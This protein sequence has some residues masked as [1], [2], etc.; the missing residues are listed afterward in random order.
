MLDFC[1]GKFVL[2][3]IGVMDIV[4]LRQTNY[5]VSKFGRK[6]PNGPRKLESCVN[7]G[8]PWLDY[9]DVW[10]TAENFDNIFFVKPRSTPLKVTP[11]STITQR[12]PKTNTPEDIKMLHS[13]Y[14]SFNRKLKQSYRKRRRYKPCLILECIFSKIAR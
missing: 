7:Y 3:N 6:K 14:E 2:N 11:F 13:H 4:G 9:Y 12:R 10:A 5:V 8:L 1:P